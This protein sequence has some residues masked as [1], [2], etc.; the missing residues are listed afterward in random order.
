MASIFEYTVMG[1]SLTHPDERKIIFIDEIHFICKDDVEFIYDTC[2]KYQVDLVLAGLETSFKF[3]P[4]ESTSFINTVVD[5]KYFLY[6]KCYYTGKNEAEYNV[7]LEN[8]KPVFDG[9]VLRPGNE[10]YVVVSPEYKDKL[11][12]GE[13]VVPL[14]EWK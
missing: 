12:K 14:K 2:M 5:V 11:L 7:L 3:E 13:K 1:L 4:F 10:E 8:G 9:S 6:G